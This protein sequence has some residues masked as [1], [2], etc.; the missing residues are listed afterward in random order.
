MEVTENE[1]APGLSVYPDGSLIDPKWTTTASAGAQVQSA[2]AKGGVGRAIL[3]DTV[4][5]GGSIANEIAFTD[6]PSGYVYLS[7]DICQDATGTTGQSIANVTVYG[8]DSSTEITQIQIQKNRLMATFGA[9]STAVLSTSQTSLTWYNLRIG[10]N[11]DT[12]NMDFWLDGVSKGS[13]YGWKGSATKISRIVISSDRNTNLST[14]KAYLDNILL[15]PKLGAVADVRD[16]GAWTPSLSKLHFSYDPVV[17]TS[18]YRYCIGTSSGGIQTRGWTVCGTSTDVMSTGLSLSENVT[19]YVTVQCGDGNGNWGSSKTSDGIKVAP[20]LISIND[21]KSLADGTA[22][23]VKALRGKLLS[24]V[25]PGCFYIQE[26]GSPFGLKVVSATPANPGD[27]VDVCGVMKGSGAERYLDATGNGVIAATGP[28]G[29]YP[30]F[31]TTASL[32]GIL[33]NA[34]TPGVLNGLGPNNIGLL[35]TTCGKFVYVDAHTFL[36]EDGSGGDV[37]S[38]VPDGITL[39][40]SWAYV[41]VTGISS[42]ESVGGELHRLLRVRRQADILPL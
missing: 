36:I 27:Q 33:F 5:A 6:K 17:Y 19:Y 29:P 16:D 35:V 30:V 24:A 11:I 28:G 26:P 38:V 34:Y 1:E 23:D 3:M 20:G 32:G 25:F 39:N 7:L 9:G 15:S 10:F 42:C 13:G 2:V 37:K 22:A 21:D 40:P 12:R 41:T 4:A 31:M 8:S 14:Q 18:Q